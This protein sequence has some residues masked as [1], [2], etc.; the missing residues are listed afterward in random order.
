MYDYGARFYMPDLGRW[1]VTDPLAEVTPH[2]SPYHYAN[3]NP[4][5]FN[6]PTGMLSQ[7]FM[8]EVW[9]S[10]SE[11]TWY[12]TGSGFVS[13]GG[14]AMDYDGNRINWGA[15]YTDMLMMSVGLSPMG[16]GGGGDVAGEIRLAP[17]ML[18]NSSIFWGIEVQN[19]HNAFM[20]RWNSRN[21]FYW[22]KMLNAG[23][24][25]DGPVKMIG[26]PSDPAGLFDIGGQLLSNWEP[27]NRHLAMGVGIVGA[28]AL[29]KPGLVTK[30]RG[31]ATLYRNFGWNELSS[32]K[33]AGGK[34]SIH[35]NQ[36]QGKQFWVGES[37]MDMWTNSSFAKPFTAKI[38]V[39]KSF[40]TPGHK[41]YIFME[42]NMMID[43]FPGG[44]V[45]PS[46]LKKFNSAIK[47]DWI[48]Y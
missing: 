2:V 42:S 43:G 46:S 47:I 30:T 6:D 12:N 45:L 24:Y 7:A 41:N 48:R 32:I 37:G 44:T 28:I 33:N 1:G 5:M 39:P 35:P 19:H 22:D 10:A 31:N 40:V 17:L 29:K 25:N 26:G 18:G 23:R 20:E 4:L 16:G 36:F 8:D 14:N 15:D 27:E 11:T 38:T 34:F 13:D 3:N 21:D 9:G